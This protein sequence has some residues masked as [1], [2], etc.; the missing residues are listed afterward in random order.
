[1][2]SFVQHNI[3]VILILTHIK[4]R[5]CILSRVTHTLVYRFSLWLEGQMGAQLKGTRT[6]VLF[7]ESTQRS[8][9]CH[10]YIS[11]GKMIRVRAAL[12]DGKSKKKR[13]KMKLQS[14][15]THLLTISPFHFIFSENKLLYRN[16]L[17]LL[18]CNLK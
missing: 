17:L 6:S 14:Q 16:I 13:R 2:C 10:R 15:T 4:M 12:M 7:H 18:T 3:I 5:R 9:I 8:K 1:M 11:L